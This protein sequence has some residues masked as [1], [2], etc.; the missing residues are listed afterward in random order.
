MVGWAVADGFLGR[1][2]RRKLDVQ[3]GKPLLPEPPEPP[4]AVLQV[5]AAGLAEAGAPATAAQALPL[6]SAAAYQANLPAP[7]AAAEP[8]EAPAPPTMADVAALTPQSDFSAFT[9]PGVDAQVRNAAMKKLFTDPH[10]NVM[11][12][13][14]TYIDDYSQPDPIPPAMLRQLASA[15]FLNLFDDEKSDAQAAPAAGLG[16]DTHRPQLPDVSQ[17]HEP[18]TTP[19]DSPCPPDPPA[20]AASH[21]DHAHPDLRLQQD[22]APAGKN[23]GGGAR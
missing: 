22:D 20:P 13:L 3:E 21:P 16:D 19:P 5:D 8:A 11:D 6:Q 1:W 4:P 18:A 7:G 14:D 15:R 2:S 9:R 23:P 12:R 17:S 10:Y